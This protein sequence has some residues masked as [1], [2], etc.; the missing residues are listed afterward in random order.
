MSWR[1]TIQDAP[2]DA[3][4]AAPESGGWRS[5]VQPVQPPVAP[6]A[7]G[8][9][10][11]VTE[12]DPDEEYLKATRQIRPDEVDAIAKKHGTDPARLMS[13]VPYLGA[14]TKDVGEAE[15][16]GL[17]S[18]DVKRVAGMAGRM[19][20]NVPQ[21]AY[22][23]LQDEPTQKAI[24]EL[25]E[26]ADRRRSG[27]EHG[28]EAATELAGGGAALAP[29]S[30]LN[31]AGEGAG[32]A[33]RAGRV[34]GEGAAVG[35]T[36]GL[37]ESKTG[38]EAQGAAFGAVT[39]AGL[40]G[41]LHGA[42]VAIPA[43]ARWF[44]GGAEQEGQRIA[45]RVAEAAAVPEEQARLQGGLDRVR[46]AA[47]EGVLPEQ[48]SEVEIQ[49]AHD[50]LTKRPDE[51]YDV[52][53]DADNS[54]MGPLPPDGEGAE[55]DLQRW[56][57]EQVARDQAAS[58]L[59]G[60]AA[61]LKR[62][63]AALKDIKDPAEVIQ[64]WAARG[65]GQQALEK[66]F[67]QFRAGELADELAADFVN[68]GG[69]VLDRNPITKAGRKFLR[70]TAQLGII[71]DRAGTKLEPIA[72]RFARAAA[73][74]NF[75]QAGFLAEQK[76]LVGDL[77][78]DF[79]DVPGSVWDAAEQGDL[80]GFN[81]QQRG[82][83]QRLQHAFETRRQL[84]NKLAGEELIP[85][86][87]GAVHYVPRMPKAPE[88]VAAA[89]QDQVKQVLE[90]A[91]V[92]LTGELT[93]RYLAEAF[94]KAPEQMRELTEQLQFITKER[95]PAEL[96]PG[97]DETWQ[98]LL[99]Q[100]TDA[101]WVK[102]QQAVQGPWLKPKQGGQV[103]G[104]LK[105][106][107]GADI[108]DSLRE[109]DP[110]RLLL[111][112][113]KAMTDHVLLRNHL[114]DFRGQVRLL[115]SVNDQAGLAYAKGLLARWEGRAETSVPAYLQ[116]QKTQALAALEARARAAERAGQAG[117]ARFLRTLGRNSDLLGAA[118]S[119]M[120]PNLLGF[121]PAS[122]L[123][124]FL[125]PAL[126]TLPEL[127]AGGTGWAL[128]KLYGGARLAARDLALRPREALRGLRETGYMPTHMGAEAYDLLRTG[129]GSGV[130]RATRGVLDTYASVALAGLQAAE[131]SARLTAIHAAES[132]ATDLLAGSESALKFLGQM[133]RGF[134]QEA[135]AAIRA[136]D[137]AALQKITADWL[138][139]R[140][141]QFYSPAHMSEMGAHF[142]RLF[143]ALS[144]WPSATAGSVARDYARHGL[145]GG[146]AQLARKAMAPL[147]ALWTFQQLMN[148]AG[149]SPDESARAHALV[150]SRGLT[151]FSQYPEALRI[152]QPAMA[153]KLTGLITGGAHGY[154]AAL[155]DA[156]HTFVPFSGLWDLLHG[157]HPVAE[158]VTGR[159]AEK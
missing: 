80:S 154:G 114:Q 158:L 31:V 99:R 123:K 109:T 33:A 84:L 117:E 90:R 55:R 144:T 87:E 69:G 139:G 54:F 27:L 20:L 130:G 129:A 23:K 149:A 15:G 64:Q 107:S 88:E 17:D 72:T 102:Q 22:K 2:A 120:Y 11:T 106:R 140:T 8:W 45:A 86:L 105:Q 122:M 100:G 13:L 28:I 104:S 77:Q 147:A 115:E 118:V 52:L 93:P 148:H 39:G 79:R 91:G 48:A 155:K 143:G 113:N 153:D 146:T 159:K 5:T 89:V 51:F 126:S 43:V 98:R 10:S 4:P 32:L 9:R 97:S 68:R 36:A 49:H 29:V 66:E 132:V 16:A 141:L 135:Q 95:P 133:G 76:G 53:Q 121:K 119:S 24:D 74:S 65:R 94:E 151:G 60:F 63:D 110:V 73:E 75:S 57:A 25:Q 142:G 38:E 50:R 138:V 30:A 108:P 1:D 96:A 85:K 19:L 136:G 92:D 59:H 18:Q 82:T 6:A 134:Q 152:T 81:E 56:A 71:D 111:K 12:A 150:G 44:R 157:N 70:A 40:A 125:A 156:A 46:R 103:A 61:E 3:A 35:A 41:A 145:G 34:L 112:W 78:R 137:K 47:A 7:E 14:Y 131:S 21:W 101:N 128:A 127:Q 116:R 37:A 124:A 58:D 83:F 62:Q 26:L 42:G 67:A